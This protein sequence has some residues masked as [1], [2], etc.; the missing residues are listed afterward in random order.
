MALPASR[1]VVAAVYVLSV[2]ADIKGV[3]RDKRSA[4]YDLARLMQLSGQIWHPGKS[5]AWFTDEGTRCQID[6]W[7][8][9]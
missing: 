8:V 4:V 6:R 1:G 9:Q 5:A 7:E 2:N 3:Y